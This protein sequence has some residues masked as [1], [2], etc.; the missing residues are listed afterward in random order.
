MAHSNS[1]IISPRLCRAL[2]AI[3]I[4]QFP[5]AEYWMN[6]SS[7]WMVAAVVGVSSLYFAHIC[8]CILTMGK[9]PSFPF[10]SIVRGWSHPKG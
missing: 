2:C 6:G 3:G 1:E 5:L 10:A 8:F 9:P 7:N 4:V